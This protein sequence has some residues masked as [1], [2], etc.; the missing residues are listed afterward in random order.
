[1]ALATLAEVK[2]LLGI[3]GTGSDTRISALLGPMG[4]A[5]EAMLGRK[6]EARDYTEYHDGR[7]TPYL[8]L[9]EQPAISVT[10]VHDD[11]GRTWASDSLL[12][13]GDY[14][15]DL[16]NGEVRLIKWSGANAFI[17]DTEE[18][19]G[20]LDETLNVRVIYRAGY[21]TADIPSELKLLL[22][23]LVQFQIN[24]VSQSGLDSESIGAYSYTKAPAA[25]NMLAAISPMGQAT[26]ASWKWRAA[27]A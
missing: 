13:S 4:A 16:P 5:I 1:M 2:A 9:R 17:R 21:E 10:S 25:L 20:Y 18:S 26:I 22:A 24:T 11:P 3:T 8:K 15:V 6:I 19:P 12:S 7:G 27:I 14:A 23:E